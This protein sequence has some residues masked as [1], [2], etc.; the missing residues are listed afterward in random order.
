VTLKTNDRQAAAGNALQ[1]HHGIRDQFERHALSRW[2]FHV[3]REGDGRLHLTC[4]HSVP[5]SRPLRPGEGNGDDGYQ[6]RLCF[7]CRRTMAGKV[8][9]AF[10]LPTLNVLP[11]PMRKPALAVHYLSIGGTVVCPVRR[12]KLTTRDPDA[13]TCVGCRRVLVKWGRLKAE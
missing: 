5:K 7:A 1:R 6:R 11:P 9:K 4:G 8:P 3:E 10:A 2:L 12:I 13:T